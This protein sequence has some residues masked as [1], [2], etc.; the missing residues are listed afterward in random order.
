MFIFLS[1]KGC[2]FSGILLHYL[3]SFLGKDIVQCTTLEPFT[4]DSIGVWMPTTILNL[5]VMIPYV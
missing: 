5:R 3:S 4:S 1:H 2:S